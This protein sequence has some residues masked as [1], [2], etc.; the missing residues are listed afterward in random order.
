M[1]HIC[2]S[3]MMKSYIYSPLIV[4]VIECY[5][6]QTSPENAVSSPLRFMLI[7]HVHAHRGKGAQ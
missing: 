7:G 4:V 6:V 1:V 5:L 2:V 3:A